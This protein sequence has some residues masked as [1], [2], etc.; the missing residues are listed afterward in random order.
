MENINTING[1]KRGFTDRVNFNQKTPLGQF[2]NKILN[3]VPSEVTSPGISKKFMIENKYV[4]GA[5]DSQRL[6][7]PGQQLKKV[8]NT[9]TESVGKISSNSK[10][11]YTQLSNEGDSMVE[12][13]AAMRNSIDSMQRI[14]NINMQSKSVLENFYKTTALHDGPSA[15]SILSTK[16]GGLNRKISKSKLEAKL[17]NK[18]EKGWQSSQSTNLGGFSL[19]MSSMQD[20][21]RKLKLERSLVKL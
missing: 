15:N 2:P 11:G 12:H 1:N 4:R 9:G 18:L 7:G 20:H 5:R 17:A 3:K 10:F 14:Q 21:K 16:R 13:D 6:F 19:Q 8:K